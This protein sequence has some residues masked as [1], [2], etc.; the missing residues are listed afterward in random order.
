MSRSPK[1][2]HHGDLKRALIDAA[3]ELL[4]NEGPGALTFRRL[5]DRVNV[6]HAAP[7]AHFPDRAALDAAIAVR[8]FQ[9]LEARL[10]APPAAITGSFPVAA[11][12]ESGPPEPP[13][14]AGFFEPGPN[15]FKR[16]FSPASPAPAPPRAQ[17]PMEPRPA[18]AAKQ[19]VEISMSYLRFAIEHPALFRTM[20][21]PQLSGAGQAETPFAELIEQKQRVNRL[22]VELVEEGQR[23]GELQRQLPAAELARLFTALA[24]GLAHQC[25]EAPEGRGAPDPGEAERLFELLVRSVG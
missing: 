9:K 20:H 8:G 21:A 12:A 4:E 1:P 24:E 22:F 13:P 25:I 5:A 19:L 18:P 17:R 2:Y 16:F 7:L 23:T 3:L 15:P 10:G 6:S 11:A 14:L